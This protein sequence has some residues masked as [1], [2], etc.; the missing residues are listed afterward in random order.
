VTIPRIL[1]IAGSDSG[2]GAGIQADIKTITMLGG[3]AMTAIT[4]VTAQNT[5]GVQSV[6]PLPAEEVQA[7]IR[8]VVSDLGID[9]VK[10]GMLANEAL[11]LAVRDILLD[12]AVPIIVD[13]VMIATS[14]D[15]LNEIG[16]AAR[17]P[18]LFEIAK[19]ITP[20]VPELAALTQSAVED[21]ISMIAAAR[22]LAAAHGC[23]VLA[24]GGHLPGSLVIDVLVEPDGAII[25]WADTRIETRHSHGTGCTLSSAIATGLASGLGLR[26]SIERARAYV[27]AALLAAPG[28]GQGHGPMGHGLARAHFAP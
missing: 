4:A 2:G 16:T 10:V 23:A 6:F 15:A 24:K 27:R 17:L 14:G 22:T 3:H 21:D 11:V 18:L 9:A 13:P 1:A 12:V 25:H 5:L 26:A 28:L 20:N 7:Q 8:S 19:L